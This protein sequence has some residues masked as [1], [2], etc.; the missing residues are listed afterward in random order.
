MERYVSA[1]IDSI[2]SQNYQDLELI[3][4]DDGSTDNTRS[5]LSEYAKKNKRIKLIFQENKGVSWATYN[6]YKAAT[7]EYICFSDH[8]DVFLPGF[9]SHLFDMPTVDVDIACCSRIDLHDVEI[10]S[11]KWQ[12]EEHITIVSGREALEN[13][14][15]PVDYNLH[16]P[17]WGRIYRKT[18]LD[19]IDFLKYSD[20]LPT[21]F[22]VDI[23][24]MPQILIKARKVAY[25][26]KVLYV[27][28]EV[29]T[30]ISRSNKLSSFYYEQID[31]YPIILDLYKD[32]DLSDLY[33]TTLKEY[34]NSCLMRLWYK[35]KEADLND[36][37]KS[38]LCRK[39]TINYNAI[40]KPLM[41]IE[42]SAVY[43]LSYMI[44]HKCKYFWSMTV[45]FMYFKIIRHRK[46]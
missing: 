44:F 14:I 25:T 3:L 11:Y 41:K 43:R 42:K 10:E 38:E 12:G 26:N 23:F 21:L 34:A 39:I 19:T 30:S 27:H 8:D 22:M 15:K 7:G 9:I 35:L 6:G 13:T 36:V 45:G 33:E 2:L 1:C 32:N 5:I 24:I 29:Q 28:R 17:L 40:Y 18:F 16:L 4:V 20:L 37:K 31:S 46:S